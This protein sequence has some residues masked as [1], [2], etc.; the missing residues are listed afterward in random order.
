MDINISLTLAVSKL[1]IKIECKNPSRYIC[2]KR[3]EAEGISYSTKSAVESSLQYS[4]ASVRMNVYISDTISARVTKF[5]IIINTLRKETNSKQEL[6]AR[7]FVCSAYYKQHR[8]NYCCILSC[9]QM[10]I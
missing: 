2:V 7:I 6:R 4:A 9:N 1:N 3:T 10:I 8:T 5:Y